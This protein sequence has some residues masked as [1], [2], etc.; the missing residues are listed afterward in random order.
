MY[1]F[2]HHCFVNYGSLPVYHLEAGHFI[3]CYYCIIHGHYENF[4]L[5]HKSY[6][7]SKFTRSGSTL[8]SLIDSLSGII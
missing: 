3:I 1:R 7:N 4:T 8:L 2:W 5:V 6:I